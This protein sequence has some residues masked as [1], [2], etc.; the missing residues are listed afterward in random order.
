MPIKRLG[1]LLVIFFS[2]VAAGIFLISNI[3]NP[4]PESSGLQSTNQRSSQ[5][6]SQIEQ[7]TTPA[8]G[9]GSTPNQQFLVSKVLDGDTI[10]IETGAKIRYIGID[11][12]ENRECFSPESTAANAQLVG[13]QRVTLVKDISET[14]K[15]GRLLRYVFINDL[16]VNDNL[17]KNGFAKAFPYGAD[18]R[19]AEKFQESENFARTS[20][21]GLWQECAGNIAGSKTK[22]TPPS[23]NCQIKGN[24]SSAGEKIYHLPGGAFYEKTQISESASER[25]FCSEDEAV[26]AGWRKSKR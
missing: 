6:Q 5:N 15:Y 16:F 10:E 14:D 17:V 7:I 11:A 22:Q 1:I 25:W 2:G 24:I 20:N 13:S 4:S 12:P 19:F 26:S 23:T 18:L 21:L 9:G 8:D 3:L